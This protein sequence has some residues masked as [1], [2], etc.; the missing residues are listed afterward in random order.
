MLSLHTRS[1][2]R[3]PRS[4]PPNSNA[5]NRTLRIHHQHA[6]TQLLIRNPTILLSNNRSTKV[7]LPHRCPN[8]SSNHKSHSFP[9]CPQTVPTTIYNSIRTPRHRLHLKATVSALL[10]KPTMGVRHLRLD[11][12]GRQVL[13]A[14][15]AAA[16]APMRRYS[17]S[18]RQS[19]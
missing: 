12:L 17:R 11:H 19:M 10:H 3:Q 5:S 7:N 14:A 15:A 9:A 2:N 6:L 8:L 1:Q 4:S 16:A 13:A 18:S